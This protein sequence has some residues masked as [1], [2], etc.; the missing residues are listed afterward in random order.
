M[1]VR[2]N[3]NT[4]TSQ[5][6]TCTHTVRSVIEAGL[7][8]HPYLVS[9]NGTHRHTLACS[10][11]RYIS[12]CRLTSNLRNMWNIERQKEREREKDR[13]DEKWRED[14]FRE[15]NAT[16]QIIGFYMIARFCFF[17]FSLY[18]LFTV[19]VDSRH[20]KAHSWS[21]IR[22]RSLEVS[23]KSEQIERNERERDA[24]NIIQCTRYSTIRRT[25]KS[26]MLSQLIIQLFARLL[27][28]VWAKD[29][30]RK[31]VCVNVWMH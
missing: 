9:A 14:S 18:V 29:N 5:T 22:T 12:S 20:M 7:I 16:S 19:H 27:T 15:R 3:G 6:L 26:A 17:F 4:I 1:F 8:S 25:N 13:H 28:S 30:L 10:S 23:T 11:I 24:K 31:C 21:H 2:T